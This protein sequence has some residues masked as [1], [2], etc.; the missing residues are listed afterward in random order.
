ME[1]IHNLFMGVGHTHKKRLKTIWKKK[2]QLKHQ[3]SPLQ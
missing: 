3:W 2:R 1:V